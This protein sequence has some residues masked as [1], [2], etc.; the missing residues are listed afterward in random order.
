MKDLYQDAH[1]KVPPTRIDTGEQ[2]LVRLREKS[3]Q[4]PDS[5]VQKSSTTSP[6]PRQLARDEFTAIL[7]YGLAP[8]RIGREMRPTVDRVDYDYYVNLQERRPPQSSLTS[9]GDRFA[10]PRACAL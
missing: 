4:P 5:Q 6:T 7:W 9:G 2:A 3:G 8:I 1:A 10:L